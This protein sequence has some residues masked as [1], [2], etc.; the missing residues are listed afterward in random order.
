MDL[1]HRVAESEYQRSGGAEGEGGRWIEVW[2][3][4]PGST[5]QVR[6]Q[7]PEASSPF[8]RLSALSV[9]QGQGHVLSSSVVV[10][11]RRLAVA[12]FSGARLGRPWP[13][14]T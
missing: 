4:R 6:G 11:R 12:V 13:D 3:E 8:V 7:Q 5:A 14:Q 1:Q 2:I 10:S 9:T